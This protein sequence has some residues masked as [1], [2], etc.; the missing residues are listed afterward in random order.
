ME[1]RA[2][3]R[4]LEFEPFRIDI[5]ERLLTRNGKPVALTPKV[6]DILLTLV[7]N[8]GRTVHKDDLMD[9][10]WGDTFVY[11]GNLNRNIS[12]LR[13]ALGETIHDPRFI[14][15]VPKRGY[16]FDHEV[17]EILLEE[18][19]VV[20]ET[21]TN[22]RLALRE[23][24]GKGLSR[25]NGFLRRVAVPIGVLSGAL[26]ISAIAWYSIQDQ[27]S[28]RHDSFVNSK[29][30]G[31]GTQNNEAHELYK[32]GRQLW[33][34]RS[35]EDLHFATLSLEQAV[36]KDPGFALAHAA[37]A[38][39]YA[40]DYANWKRAEAAANEAIRLDPNIGQPYATIGFIR[41]FWEWRLDDAEHYFRQAI[42]KSPDYAT[43]HQWYA[44]N[45]AARGRTGLAM[46][47]INRA[48]ELDPT[49]A[50]V[51]ADRC[52]LSYFYGKYD[53]ALDQ[54]RK[55]LEMDP[56]S[57][58]ARTS[59]YD[60]YMSLQMY[61]EAVE[62][63]LQGELQNLSPRSRI[64]ELRTAYLAKDIRTF[65]RKRIDVLKHESASEFQIA[66]Y[67]ALLGDTDEA[68]SWLER[69]RTARNFQ[70]IFVGMDPWF[71]GISHDQRYKELA[72]AFVTP[73]VNEN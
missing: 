27:S 47:Q 72:S 35:V 46:A 7:E 23:V 12:T 15:T 58:N 71:Q 22:Y 70:L 16:R 8:R 10:V 39:A 44:I 49:S 38:D 6:F 18:E 20:V 31:R 36:Q 41:T 65:W 54:C 30:A 3:K 73:L 25:P 45:L 40:F 68:I 43:G 37:L 26:I 61:D 4:L 42:S 69:A 53:L 14:L 21:K 57:R 1:E 52:Q 48:A 28:P 63:F 11:E 56:S 32:K 13:K 62:E 29:N 2:T 50:A 19:S 55:T 24:N 60:I 33:E 66:R 17:K 59:L 9:K 51:S 34:T 5:E 67:H 64:D